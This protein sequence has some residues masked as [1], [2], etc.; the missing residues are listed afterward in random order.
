MEDAHRYRLVLT[1]AGSDDQ[2]VKIARALV[3][4]GL[5]ACVNIVGT[6][7]SIYRWEGRIEQE[8]ERLLLIKTSRELLP[9]VRETIRSNHAYDVP[10]LLTLPLAEGDP[11]YLE[12]LAA[13]LKSAG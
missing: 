6:V 12:W 5:A 9:E 1:T 10:E 8:Q 11:A 4:E 2:A 3:G 7:C 13:S